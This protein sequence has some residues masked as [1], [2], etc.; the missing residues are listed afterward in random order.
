[1]KYG[2]AI[3][4]SKK[5][6]DFAN[7][8]RKRYDPH[9]ALITPHVTLKEGFEIADDQVDDVAKDLVQV[10]KQTKPF[11]INISKV[12]TFSPVTNTIYLKIDPNESL[13]SLHNQLNK[14]EATPE[15]DTFQF[16]PHITIAQKLSDD[17][18]SDVYG[19]LRMMDVSFEDLVDR[20]QLLY[21]LDNGSW[22]V[23]ETFR[24]GE[25]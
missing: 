19:S 4:P 5:I 25:E 7:S 2:I 16:V 12:S 24:L 17:E 23:Y 21:Q 13:T 8:Y 3:F 18:Y 10:A 22:T 6:Q 15:K 20:F 14:V 1:M 11:S 9:Y